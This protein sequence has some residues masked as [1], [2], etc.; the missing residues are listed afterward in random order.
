MWLHCT[1]REVDISGQCN[2]GACEVAFCDPEFGC[3]TTSTTCPEDGDIC[4][5]A[6]CD[7]LICGTAGGACVTQPNP[8][9]LGTLTDIDGIVLL[10]S[11]NIFPEGDSD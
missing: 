10:Q 3:G 11:G 8:N 9:D 6:V 7:P 4:T 5:V 2:A 1:C